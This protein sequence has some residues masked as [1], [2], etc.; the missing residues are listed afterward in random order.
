MKKFFVPAVLLCCLTACSDRKEDNPLVSS[1]VAPTLEVVGF[2]ADTLVYVEGGSYPFEFVA[3]DE[4]S[5]E[6]E[7]SSRVVGATG[8]VVLGQRTSAGRVQAT[9]EPFNLGAHQIEITVFDGLE[10]VAGEI[11]VFMGS[12]K[13]PVAV[14]SFETIS[15][16]IDSGEF[17][18][19]FDASTSSDPDSKI[20]TAAWDLDGAS[21]ERNVLTPFAHTFNYYADYAIT[22]TITDEHG[23]TS[24]SSMTI[25]NSRPEAVFQILPDNETGN[26]EEITLNASGSAS[27]Q[28]RIEQYEWLLSS[29]ENDLNVLA[30]VTTSIFRTELLTPVGDNRVG[31]IVTDQE[32]SQSDTVWAQLQ[33][34]NTAPQ[35]LFA[36]T[37]ALEQI[38][39]T[40]NT[41]SD[42]DPGEVLTFRW[43][44]DGMEMPEYDNQAT[45][46]LAV[47]GG[48]YDITLQVTDSHGDTGEF[49]K[50]QLTVPGLPVANFVF[51]GLDENGGAKN[52]TSVT[53]DA[54]TSEAGEGGRRIDRYSWHWRPVGGS[55]VVLSD[56]SAPLLR[57]D[58]NH[59]VGDYEIGLDVV[60]DNGLT[61]LREWQLFSVAN[62]PPVPAFH[63]GVSIGRTISVSSNNSFDI[64]PDQTIDFTWLVDG[65]IDSASEGVRLPRWTGLSVGSHT[66]TL[67]VTDSAGGQADLS[68]TFTT[69]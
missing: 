61:S 66:I 27:P 5:Q 24:T 34:V 50:Q 41:S 69:I 26:G 14:V 52:A 63:A 68:K 17:T 59:P 23:A 25:D 47:L 62:S 67:R 40:S 11:R 45:P 2:A 16:N 46:T 15:R 29:P 7:I 1:N 4:A 51:N 58:L 53:L 18:Y 32:G 28:G 55:A 38:S 36:C 42:I 43:L 57:V 22:L 60:N 54:G 33:V 12:N 31:L 44:L 65:E 20:V 39:V 21:L 8:L 37:S 10:Q 48:I 3:Q 35:A 6:P 9:F 30:Q 64:D 19:S 49:T 13:P 56:T